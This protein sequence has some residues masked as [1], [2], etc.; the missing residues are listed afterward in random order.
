MITPIIDSVPFRRSASQHPAAL[1]GFNL[2][3]TS[4]MS[5]LWRSTLVLAAVTTLLLWL[6]WPSSAQANTRVGSNGTPPAASQAMG[7]PLM[8]GSRLQGQANLRLWGLNIYNAR[9]WTLTSFRADLLAQQPWVLELEYQRE[10]KGNSIADRSLSEMLR[11]GPIPEPQAQQWLTFMQ[12]IFPDVKAGDKLTG[13]HHPGQGA[14]FAHNGRH[15]GRIDD[16]EFA[17]RFFGIW[18]APTTSQPDMRL[19]LLGLSPSPDR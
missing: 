14:S 19:A 11:A 7:H 2:E 8:P 15:I 3:V 6:A 16:A 1:P 18:L 9:L 4:C 13:L 12:R 5:R 17:S 10:L